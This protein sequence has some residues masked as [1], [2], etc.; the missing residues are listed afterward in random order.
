MRT[1]PTT[2]TDSCPAR[3][4][5]KAPGSTGRLRAVA[6]VLLL[7][8]AWSRAGEAGSNPPLVPAAGEAATRDGATPAHRRGGIL[9]LALA[10]DPRTFDPNYVWAQLDYT[11]LPLFF[12]P[13]I[14]LVDGNRL[15][16][17]LTSGWTFSAD[18][19]VLTFQLLP[20]VRFSNGR[21]ATAEDYAFALERA[22]RAPSLC[23][24][25]A[26]E[27]KGATNRLA[28][29]A[30]SVAGIS[31]P[32]RYTLVVELARPDAAF[33]YWIAQN[34]G[35]ALARETLAET[36]KDVGRRP[37]GTGPYVVKEW[38]RGARLRLER[39]PFYCR[40]DQQY[41]DA[42][43]FLIG[44][45]DSTQ[46]MMFERGELDVASLGS[47]G[48]AAADFPRLRRDPRWR[49]HWLQAPLFNLVNLS[50]NVEMPPLND[51]RVRRAIVCALDR[52][53]FEKLNGERMTPGHGLITPT[54]AGFNPKLPCAR[55][56]AEQ[57][58]TLLHQ[59]GFPAGLPQPLKLWHINS[60]SG[61]R[62]AQAIQS[63]LAQVGIPV[64]LSGVTP[65]VF[66]DVTARRGG[67]QLA[68]C[69]N[70]ANYPDPGA[71]LDTFHSRF[72]SDEDAQN[73]CFYHNPQVDALLSRA[74][75]CV[76]EPRRL[77]LYQAAERM[78][79][80]DAPLVVLG[81]ANLFALRQPW[82]KGP[83]LEPFWWFRLDRVWIER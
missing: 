25:F 3:A 51:V 38:V 17:N 52:Q 48:V 59:A 55:Y 36:L 1:S 21:E 67:A 74:S 75:T 82:L 54:M 77:E 5:A 70:N 22:V 50:F 35:M 19:Q 81:H 9:R 39:N 68:L 44:A 62:W 63:D 79:L 40:P 15:V 83:L 18:K 2:T 42:I 73:S 29:T 71:F 80:E 65:A 7:L 57:A 28:G 76:D 43:E 64:E 24:Q 26:L 56:D 60:A 46:T 45:D 32:A 69:G 8:V 49:D 12:Q 58:R 11:L 41:F 4:R 20:G 61:R 16:N 78:I 31:T 27:I 37:I 6:G 13:L 53:H 33:P 72:I 23:Q 47:G 10:D 14:D 30:K 34:F 66:G